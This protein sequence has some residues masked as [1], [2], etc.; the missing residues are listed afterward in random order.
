MYSL[1]DINQASNSNNAIPVIVLPNP[2]TGNFEVK[3]MDQSFS[4]F[5]LSVV[6]ILGRLRT[7][8]KSNAGTEFRS[9]TLPENLPS[10][11]KIE[12]LFS[13]KYL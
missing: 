2:S 11:K 12:L 13:Y 5:K 10:G 7:E 4:D 9:F 8:F 1:K 6:D 3:V